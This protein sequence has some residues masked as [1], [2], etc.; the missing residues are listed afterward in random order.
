MCLDATSP[1][2][3]TPTL[4]FFRVCSHGTLQSKQPHPDELNDSHVLDQIVSARR[5]RA[6]LP[7]NS[8]GRMKRKESL[9]VL[10]H[11]Q[12]VQSTPSSFAPLCLIENPEHR[13]LHSCFSHSKLP[14]LDERYRRLSCPNPYYGSKDLKPDIDVNSL[15]RRNSYPVARSTLPSQRDS[16]RHASKLTTG[17]SHNKNNSSKEFVDRESY[18]DTMLRPT[19]GSFPNLNSFSDSRSF[20][21]RISSTSVERNQG[22]SNSNAPIRKKGLL[23]TDESVSNGL[24]FASC[25]LQEPHVRTHLD[26]LRGVAS[27][28]SSKTS[29]QSIRE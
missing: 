3:I 6:S 8:L 5:R 22:D 16:F 12:R 21:A 9:E 29:L 1:L 24:I 11:L 17:R 10:P 7:E 18:P 13:T 26:A 19:T 28:V 15:K 27:H 14:H 2:S 23:W 20:S 25:S 4:L